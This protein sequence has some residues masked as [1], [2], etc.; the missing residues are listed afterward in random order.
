GFRIEPGEIEATLN[1]QPQ[2][3]ESVVVAREDRPGEKRLVAYVV[4][5]APGSAIE[6]WPCPGDYRLY[7][8]VT[9]YAMTHDD[10]R[11]ERY[12][13]AIRQLVRDKVVVDIG[14]GQDVVLARMCVEAGARKV[15]AIE[16]QEGAY[17]RA[18]RRVRS[19]GLE[20]KIVVIHGDSAH[21]ELPEKVDVCVS[22]LIGAIGNSEGAAVILNDA[23]RFLK[24]NGIMIPDRS[25]TH[26]P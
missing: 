12:R 9:Y 19:L 26:I 4:P 11:N 20:E 25:T 18:V 7:D 24:E 8:E 16:I 5:H 21:A 3:K 6:L 13:A 14:T 23:R 15:Y 10:A 1:R 17:Q 2:V 22:E